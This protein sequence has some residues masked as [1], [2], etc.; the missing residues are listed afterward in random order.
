MFCA[1]EKPR[2]FNSLEEEELYDHWE[3]L[4]DVPRVPEWDDFSTFRDWALKTGYKSG[5]YICRRY[6]DQPLGPLNYR[7]V[8]HNGGYTFAEQEAI[9]RWNKTVNRIRAAYGLPLF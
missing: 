5:F 3:R 6:G 2:Y 9:D 7:I 1:S 8:T 4:S